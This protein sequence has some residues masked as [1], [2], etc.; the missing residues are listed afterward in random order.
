[1]HIGCRLLWL[2]WGCLVLLTG[3]NQ[4]A[5]D[6]ST[7][8]SGT[9]DLI[10]PAENDVSGWKPA[11]PLE[12]YQQDNLFDLVDGGA[13][14]YLAYGFK[15]AAVRRYQN[16]AGDRLTVQVWKMASPADAYGLFT[17]NQ[18]GTAVS[19]GNGGAAEPGVRLV[20]WQESCFVVI[21]A[22]ASLPDEVLQSF[23]ALLSSRLPRGGELPALVKRLPAD[24]LIANNRR[25]FHV[26]LSIQDQIW[27][28]GENALGLSSQTNGVLA[29]YELEGGPV[30]LMLIEYP[31]AAG[32]AAAL[33]ALRQIEDSELIAAE[34]QANLLGAVFGQADRAATQALLAEG[35]QQ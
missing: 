25:F 3:C 16:A 10:F 31:D 32:A 7:G 11:A 29:R 22:A 6:S 23:A 18:S 34:T 9:G 24:G 15:Q 35:L 4:P 21:N 30:R 20:F 33:N 13:D 5:A 14:S 19:V 26:E 8:R 2:F 27:L 12:F 1:L 28:G 17:V